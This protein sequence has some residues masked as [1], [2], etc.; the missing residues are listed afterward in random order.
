MN[1]ELL[2]SLDFQSFI[3]LPKGGRKDEK[4]SEALVSGKFSSLFAGY[5]TGLNIAV[6]VWRL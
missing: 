1:E 3:T 4:K 5:A 2:S 6:N